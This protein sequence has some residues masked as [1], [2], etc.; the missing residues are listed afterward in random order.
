MKINL[1]FISTILLFNF[2]Y[3]QQIDPLLTPV[4][5]D[6]NHWNPSFS[7]DGNRV[8]YSRLVDDQY[9]LFIHDI[10]TSENIQLTELPSNEWRPK[11][12]PGNLIAFS[13]DETGSYQIYTID[14]DD[15]TIRQITEGPGDKQRMTWSP[16]GTR[17]AYDSN[18]GG[19]YDIYIME[20]ASG[21]Q[22]KITAN[23]GFDGYP[24]WS[25]DGKLITY[26]SDLHQPD[27]KSASREIY[28]MTTKG[29]DQI[30]W[31][32]NEAFD[33]APSLSPDGQSIAFF[34][35]VDGN[36]EIY[37]VS[38]TTKE[39]TRL[40]ENE[41]WDFMPVWS[42][43]GKQIAFDSRRDGRRGIYIMDA[44]GANQMKLTNKV[45]SPYIVQLKGGCLEKCIKNYKSYKEDN[46]DD[47]YYLAPELLG[48]AYE[49]AMDQKVEKTLKL[50]DFHL[51]NTDFDPSVAEKLGDYLVL[52][53]LSGQAN[54]VYRQ[55]L[56][57][58]PSSRLVDKLGKLN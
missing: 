56:Q 34:S 44:N 32:F 5:D 3:G 46:P 12:G 39:L 9:E 30:R 26:N 57:G 25:K 50:L 20:L 16:D 7:P 54:L 41:E 2:T 48:L 51:K 4:S 29:K 42:N 52:F 36:A 37:K 21:K 18:E 58:N 24:D 1:G 6:E 35:T 38:I 53:G 8:V 43:D 27:G 19:N 10:E 40:T 49:W 55:A 23:P 17:L 13:S 45:L 15:Y 22:E 47:N 11:W 31:T 14:T 33:Q 28:S